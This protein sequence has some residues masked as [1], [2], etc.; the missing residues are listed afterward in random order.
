MPAT[1][2][3]TAIQRRE[4][5]PV[6]VMEALLTRI[7]TLNPQLNAFLA[8]DAERARTA[9]KV[10]E[11]AVM[12]GEAQGLLHG[13]P[14]SIKDLEPVAGLRYTLGSK[15]TEHQIADIDGAVTRRVKAAGG[16]ITGKTNTSHYGH[17]D[18]C[19]NLLGD[20]CRNPWKRDI[21]WWC[22]R[23]SCRRNG[24]PS[25]W[26]GWRGIDSHSV[27]PVRRIWPQTVLRSGTLLA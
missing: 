20:A 4:L 24:T 12:H 23:L 21:E 25:A 2:L 15:F 17:K 3:A 5:S 16:I 9:A 27:G 7:E 19:D 18:M 26:F 8:V 6:D 11:D 1:E 10:A 13:L 14:V 22:S